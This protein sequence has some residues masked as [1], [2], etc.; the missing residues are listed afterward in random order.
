MKYYS[1][2]E[3]RHGDQYSRLKKDSGEITDFS[4]SLSHYVIESKSFDG[5]KTLLYYPTVEESVEDKIASYLHF[6]PSQVVAFA[7]MTPLIHTVFDLNGIEDVMLL[8]PLFSEYRKAST[9]RNMNITRLP[10]FACEKFKSVLGNYKFDIVCLNNPVNPTGEI[11]SEE[12]L[13]NIAK[14][15]KLRNAILFLDQAYLD[16][17]P[18]QEKENSLKLLEKYDNIILGRTFTKI[19]GLPGLRLG[20]AITT[21]RIA[22]KLRNLRP[23]WTIAENSINYIGP[24]LK[25]VKDPQLMDE[26]LYLK[27]E[28]LSMGFRLIGDSKINMIA[29]EISQNLDPE[30]FYKDLIRSGFL[31][32]P[33]K[34]FYGFSEYSFRVSVRGHE[35]NKKL[36]REMWRIRNE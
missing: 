36:M 35:D 12:I 24:I 28:L 16:F 23:P 21:E 33:L 5:N 32:R 11:L 3:F 7:G 13:T 31:I 22:E 19:T 34:N 9:V 25:A 1:H 10:L 18:Q 20:Y 2:D 8:E 6:K 14:A 15:A 17:S 29:F 30:L 4:S 27:K 26:S